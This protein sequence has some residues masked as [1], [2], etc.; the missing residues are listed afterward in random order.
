MH[1][2]LSTVRRGDK[3]YRYAQLVESYRREQDGR[4]AHRIV[5]S[6][7]ALSDEAIANLRSALVANRTGEALVVP[8]RAVA[9]VAKPVV[10]ANYRFL[11]VAVLLRIWK[12]SGVAGLLADLLADPA[13]QVP[14]DQVIAALVLHRCLEPGS[15]LAAWRWF[16]TTAL[17]ELLAIKPG[18]FNNSRVHR[19]LEALELVDG[20]LQAR[21][22][23]VVQRTQGGSVRLFIDATDT[24][25]VGAGPPLAAK[26]LDKQGLY[27]RRVG[28]V[29]LCDER[30]FPMRWETLSGRYH[31]PTALLDM[32]IE[33]GK[34]DWVG[35]KPIVLDRAAGNAG[36]VEKLLN[37]GM[38]F[39]TALPSTEF[40]SCGA[41]IPW[42]KVAA[43]QAAC[44]A[45]GATPASIAGEG[46]KLGFELPRDDR[47]LLDLNVFDKAPPR[48]GERT[49]A[50]VAAMRFARQIKSKD[51]SAF[52]ALAEAHGISV[53]TARRHR[54]LLPLQQP[55]QLRVLAGQADTVSLD[56][57]RAIAE[58]PEAEQRAAFEV[59]IATPGRV[60]PARSNPD[61]KRLR[62]RGVLYFNPKRFQDKRDADTK[63]LK[64][65]AERVAEQNK[66]LALAGNRRTDASALA[67]AHKQ[68]VRVGLGAVLSPRMET[69]EGVRTVVLD[70]DEE[71]WERRRQVDGVAVLVSHPDLKVTA[72]NL[73]DLYFEK[74]VVEKD[75]QTIKSAIELRPIHHRTDVKLH[76]HV[77]LCML[78]LLIQRI[79]R[80]RL[81]VS[82]AE[83]SAT[84]A[85]ETLKTAH[86]NLINHGKAE[87]YTLTSPNKPQ[88]SL[89]AAL[90]MEDLARDDW[91]A[92][93]ITPR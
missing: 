65:V 61:A 20:T 57:L 67:A 72:A 14:A 69:A 12:E 45:S 24:W 70:L 50:V 89:L 36:A 80:E 71:A 91:V 15:K 82:A 88:H 63:N 37:T 19:A 9:A 34:L 7:G 31:D 83:T 81:K 2:R 84:A 90:A 13:D 3:T 6:L 1:L 56:E 87:F 74:D 58:K 55:I 18:Q 86:L 54:E 10:R 29:L 21:L 46:K 77:T 38:R 52:S 62:T 49:S 43:L 17:A 79:L 28:I 78:A 22:P 73:V 93:N 16:P 26:G 23:H 44:E 68:I 85:L 60:T 75:F 8:P 47:F 76:A 59:A 48:D 41:P 11:D 35:N 32:A 30:G 39:L 53:R 42:D 27:R 40:V 33:A 25:F 66:R 92:Q 4:P 5:A 64:H 51:A